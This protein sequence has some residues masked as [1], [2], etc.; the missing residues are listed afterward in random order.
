MRD[1]VCN[2]I[3]KIAMDFLCLA[4]PT[5]RYHVGRPRRRRR[6]RREAASGWGRDS[7]QKADGPRRSEG[8]APRA[9][10]PDGEAVR[11][12]LGKASSARVRRPRQR[13]TDSIDPGLKCYT[14]RFNF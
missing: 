10:L 4:S 2:K 7:V 6:E 9:S 8:R 1:L 3:P 14:H 12:F 11:C 5:C 13:G